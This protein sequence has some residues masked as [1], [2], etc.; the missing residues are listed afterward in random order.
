M[1]LICL[2]TM[3]A[4]FITASSC[5]GTRNLQQPD[6]TDM[7][8]TFSE[9]D[10]SA[11]TFADTGWWDF[12][13][14]DNLVNIIE[15]TLAHN[16][17]FLAAGARVEELRQLYGAERVNCLPSVTGL[18]QSTYETNNYRGSGVTKDPEYDLKATVA[19]EAN[20]WG[21]LSHARG[22]AKAGYLA[23]AEEYRAL[24]MTLVAEAATAYFN[25]IALDN[26]L[27]I[28]K[29]TLHTRQEALRMAKLRYE[30]GLTSETV[31]QQAVVEYS[32]TAAMVPNLELKIS[33]MRNA[34]TLLMGEFPSE[35]LARGRFTVDVDMPGKL[36]IGLPSS[37][38]Q[39]RP[40]IRA[41]EMKLR[42]AME[43]VGLTYADRFPNFRIA[44]T[45]GLENDRLKDFLK[46]PFSYTI[47]SITGSIFDFGRKKRKYQAAIAAFDQA[48]YAYEQCVIEA[49][50]EVENAITV[51]RRVRESTALKTSLRDAA[52][53]YVELAVVQNRA[54]ALAYID[55]L[56]AQR[57]YFDAQVGLSNA[58]RDECL[59]L[60]SLYKVLGGGA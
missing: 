7:P 8:L 11:I 41:A 40:D 27:S 3:T 51:Y 34:I 4:L 5:S 29:Q 22:K 57:R 56:D 23:S 24:Q 44:F 20:L 50:T 58:R 31:Y 16:R 13:A 52:L 1:K 36:E 47:G 6:L 17:D 39:R 38:L 37:L 53:K 18:A 49:F 19:W 12:Y 28:V 9:G 14:D 25:L 43:N 45:G 33:T 59:A 46:S 48:R 30:G 21:A 15:K 10:T 42:Q 60:V 35:T 32:T 54:G 26:E 55:V 2:A